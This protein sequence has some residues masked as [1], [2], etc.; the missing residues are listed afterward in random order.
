V[1]FSFVFAG[2][3]APLGLWVSE[4]SFAVKALRTLLLMSP[5]WGWLFIFRRQSHTLNA[6]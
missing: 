2:D 1:A 4:W 3:V 5:R 6:A